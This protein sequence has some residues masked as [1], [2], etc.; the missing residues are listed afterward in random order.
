LRRNGMRLIKMMTKSNDDTFRTV[1]FSVITNTSLKQMSSSI[2]HALDNDSLTII[3]SF[4][5][6][7]SLGR[8]SQANK[9]INELTES[10]IIWRNIAKRCHGKR[11][12]C[13]LSFKQVCHQ[14]H[15]RK[16]ERLCTPV[17]PPPRMGCG[18]PP[19]PP[20]T[21]HVL[22]YHKYIFN[23]RANSIQ[24]WV[25]HPGDVSSLFP[26]EL[27]IKFNDLQNLIELVEFLYGF[28]TLMS[29]YL[30]KEF[31]N[32]STAVK[33][34]IHR[35]IKFMKL[36]KKYPDSILVPTHDIM[37]VWISHMIRPHKYDMDCKYVFYFTEKPKIDLHLNN[38]IEIEFRSDLLEG[39]K[40]IWKQEYN[41]D[42]LLVANISVA[43]LPTPVIPKLFLP[44]KSEIPYYS[45]I[46]YNSNFPPPPP[47]PLSMILLP[48][49]IPPPP[50]PKFPDNG[51][52]YRD[53]FILDNDKKNSFNTWVERASVDLDNYD[54]SLSISIDE[55][56]E[57]RGWYGNFCDFIRLNGSSYAYVF[58]ETSLHATFT[59]K[60][61]K[62]Y[63]K[64]S[65][66]ILLVSINTF[67]V[68]SFCF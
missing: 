62:A 24:N 63:E 25:K 46:P 8:F 42:Y 5:D 28:E 14:L 22:E 33:A 43:K 39:T 64:V 4:A 58:H 52:N 9:H 1:R 3:L 11:K 18:P 47:P 6:I 51:T 56:L 23:Y 61:L 36:K 15:L 37:M 2:F 31:M 10:D 44:H 41:E 68:N 60:C 19:P 34:A 55:V 32:N 7:K 54:N 66:L 67:I 29:K 53:A 12:P 20:Q 50:R 27:V 49:Y 48:Y 65:S 40:K 45:P 35:Y 26:D 57:D 38:D 59:C 13:N 16:M 17:T 30:S 21:L